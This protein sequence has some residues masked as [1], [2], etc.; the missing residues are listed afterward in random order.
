MLLNF[1]IKS[2]SNRFIIATDNG[3]I[4]AMRKASPGKEFIEAPT[5]GNGATCKS[6]AHCP[7]MEMNDLQG[8]VSVLENST[9]EIFVP[10]ETSMKAMVAIN[11]MLDFTK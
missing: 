3:L 4:H 2:P 11:K 10:K 8:I 7:W 6:C 5:A 9:G 1:S